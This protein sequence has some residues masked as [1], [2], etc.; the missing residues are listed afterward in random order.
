MLTNIATVIAPMFICAAI[1]FLWGRFDRPFDSAMVTGLALNIGMPALI[2]SALTKL[3]VSTEAFAEMA[4]V[5]TVAI[6]CSLVFGA[7]V[8]RLMRLDIRAFLPAL[9]FTNNGNMGLPLALFAFGEEGLSFAIGTFVIASIAGLTIG[10]G[11]SSGRSSL[12]I[13]YKNPL[14]YAIGAALVFMVGGY[15]PPAWLANTAEIVGGMAIPLMIISLGVAISKLEVESFS[16]SLCLSAVRLAF[17]FVLGFSLAEAFG[18][19]GAARGV[20]I[21]QCSMPVAMHNYVFAQRFDRR[22]SEIAGMVMIS[23]A[24]SYVTLPLLLWVVL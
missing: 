24:L 11:I 1:G 14:V 4:G 15:Q 20:L 9:T 21:L 12:D 7:V 17:G 2:F 8:V 10:G 5:Y 23:T 22:P 6:L 18:L 16:R 13:V 19:T 3:E